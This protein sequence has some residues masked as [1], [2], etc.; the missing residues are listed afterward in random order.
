[1]KPTNLSNIS[2]EDLYKQIVP[3]YLQNGIHQR[4]L[5]RRSTSEIVKQIL[6]EDEEE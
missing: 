4:F 1:M 2:T 6:F 3:F 5:T